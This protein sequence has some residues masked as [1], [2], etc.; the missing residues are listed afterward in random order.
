[1]VKGDKGDEN[2]DG[3]SKVTG[4]MRAGGRTSGGREA[5]GREAGG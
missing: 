4:E 2:P 1:M 3:K 5:G